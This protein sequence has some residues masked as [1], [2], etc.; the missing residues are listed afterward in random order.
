M[1]NPQE[2]TRWREWGVDGA[3]E[4]ED[5]NGNHNIYNCEARKVDIS[6]PM[7]R[8]TEMYYFAS[9]K[10]DRHNKLRSETKID[11]RVRTDNWD[12]RVNYFIL[13][14]IFADTYLLYRLFLVIILTKKKCLRVFSMR[15]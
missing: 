12:R 4:E 9:N 6:I 5:D 11:W 8:A 15:C 1:G 2:R 13:G 14:M 7:P 3:Y 10:I